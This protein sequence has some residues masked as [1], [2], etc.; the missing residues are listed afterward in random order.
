ML[1]R[2]RVASGL[3]AVLAL[4]VLSTTSAYGD[5]PLNTDSLLQSTQSQTSLAVNRTMYSSHSLRASSHHSALYLRKPNS[6]VTGDDVSRIWK[7]SPTDLNAASNVK[8][9]I[10]SAKLPAKVGKLP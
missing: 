7:Q 4:S 10:D 1:K 3:T 8:S 2:V 5:A 6:L 9:A